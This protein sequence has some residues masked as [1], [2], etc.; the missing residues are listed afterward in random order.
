MKIAAKDMT[1]ALKRHVIPFLRENGFS[2]GTGRKLW[3]HR[4]GKTDHV[5]FESHSAYRALVDRC[6]T[7]SFTVRLGISLQGYG[8]H[9]DPYHK[10]YIKTGP[11]GPRPDESQ[12]P[13]RGVLCPGEAPPLKM[14]HWGWDYQSLWEINTLEDA[15]KAALD[16]RQQFETFA[17]GW[18]D[19][20]WDLHEIAG[21]LAQKEAR[22]FLVT[23]ANGSHLFL[24]AELYGSPIRQAHVAMV[25]NALE[26]RGNK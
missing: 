23:A 24:N 3:R 22:L 7:A 15:E 17:L 13:I 21:L 14:G 18:L 2:D 19:R 20:D 6:T 25:A 1:K 10:D 11:L 4:G 5:T 26:Q 8:F 16:L 12:M 9:N